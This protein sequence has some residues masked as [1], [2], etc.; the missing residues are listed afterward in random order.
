MDIN[1]KI[2][3]WNGELFLAF[4]ILTGNFDSKISIDSVAE[5]LNADDIKSDKTFLLAP[6]KETKYYLQ[7]T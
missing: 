1:F 2:S 4:D 6:L 3:K 5:M 7:Q